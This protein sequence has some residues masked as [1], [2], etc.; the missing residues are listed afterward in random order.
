MTQEKLI[1]MIRLAEAGIKNA[2]HLSF[3]LRSAGKIPNGHGEDNPFREL[4]FDL[5]ESDAQLKLIRTR[6]IFLCTGEPDTRWDRVRWKRG[7]ESDFQ[8]IAGE[9]ARLI[10]EIKEVGKKYLC[11]F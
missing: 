6:Y 9:L 3:P 7:K 2:E 8:T 10:G 5:S 1:G 4:D 11:H